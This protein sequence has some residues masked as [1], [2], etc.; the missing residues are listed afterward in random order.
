MIFD[1][2]N[3]LKVLLPI[4]DCNKNQ[5]PLWKIQPRSSWFPP[6]F[7][8]LIAREPSPKSAAQRSAIPIVA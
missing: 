3:I 6:T 8:R 4:G 7:Q 1:M 5:L 2:L